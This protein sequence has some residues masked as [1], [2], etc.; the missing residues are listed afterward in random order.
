[1]VVWRLFSR[2]RFSENRPYVSNRLA[3][4]YLSD[5]ELV[6]VALRWSI[7]CGAICAEWAIAA[8]TDWLNFVFRTQLSCPKPLQRSLDGALRRYV[9]FQN[10]YDKFKVGDGLFL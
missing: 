7:L 9:F 10:I 8:H 4:G 3:K 2:Y 5:G 6:L 1:M